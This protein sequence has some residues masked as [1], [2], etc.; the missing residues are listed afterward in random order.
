MGITGERNR[1]DEGWLKCAFPFQGYQQ[2]RGQ[3]LA[4][5]CVYL[6]MHLEVRADIGH[7]PGS[8]STFLFEAGSLTEPGYL[9]SIT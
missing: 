3:H 7:L 4:I 9:V 8:L 2:E 6:H 5:L 1:K